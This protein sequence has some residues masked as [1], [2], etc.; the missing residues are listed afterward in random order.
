[1]AATIIEVARLAGVSPTTVSRAFTRPDLLNAD[2][3]AT[4]LSAAEQLGYTP[5][6][7][8]KGLVTGKT[9]NVG[10]L[11]PDIVNPF[12][13]PVVKGAT[14]RASAA[15]LAVF[16]ATTELDPRRELKV[17]RGMAKQVDGLVLCATQLS[18]EQLAGLAESCP[19]VLLNAESPGLPSV[20][21]DAEPG[22]TDA[23]EHLAALGHNGFI[24]LSG[25]AASW[26][27]T[28]R[29]TVLRREAERLG[30]AFD[31]LGPFAASYDAGVLAAD[32]VIAS[33]ATAVVAFD[34]QMAL[35]VLSR[36]HDRG[37]DV[38]GRVSVV[39]CDGVL[40]VGMARPALTTVNAPCARVGRAAVEVVLG[41]AR[42][43]RGQAFEGYLVV[44]D[45]TGPRG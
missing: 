27:N 33:G 14:D 5:N 44:R 38:P 1:M 25:P 35:G 3:R 10:I 2:T 18:A 19:V 45:S 7:A 23:V 15:D 20:V 28:Q 36:L 39:G 29:L 41:D 37:V 8:A 6:R 24:Y 12:Y 16:L 22:M 30:L 26:S 42:E 11:V 43:A 21:V 31:V 34:D 40:P 9:G 4:V 13:P 32:R 17:A